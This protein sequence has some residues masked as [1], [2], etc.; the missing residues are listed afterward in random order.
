MDT[1]SNDVESIATVE[2]LEDDNKQN[3]KPISW[4]AI[5]LSLAAVAIIVSIVCVCILNKNKAPSSS[6]SDKEIINTF[7]DNFMLV[8]KVPRPSHHEERNGR[9]G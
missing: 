9:I 7:V 1:K 6:M 3:K 4:W 5:G 2:T 8:A